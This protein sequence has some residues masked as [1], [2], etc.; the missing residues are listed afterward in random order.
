VVPLSKREPKEFRPGKMRTCKRRL[1]Y[2]SRCPTPRRWQQQLKL[3]RYEPGR[4]GVPAV[5]TLI[6]SLFC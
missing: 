2:T 6:S 1:R 3:T 5:D 4:D